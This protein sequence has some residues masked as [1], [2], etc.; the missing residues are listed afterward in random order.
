MTNKPIKFFPCYNSLTNHWVNQ[1]LTAITSLYKDHE[2]VGEHLVIGYYTLG[3]SG[4]KIGILGRLSLVWRILWHG[5][6][7]PCVINMN[8]VV[9]KNFA[10]HLLYLLNKDRN[11]SP[12]DLLVKDE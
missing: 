1:G 12:K 2:G 6:I 10:Y 3:A 11:P 9:A 8:K 5:T 4:A 7:T